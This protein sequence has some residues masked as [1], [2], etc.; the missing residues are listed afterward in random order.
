MRAQL[1]LLSARF[2]RL[3]AAL[4]S[5]GYSSMVL[6]ADGGS[7]TTGIGGLAKGWGDTAGALGTTVGQGVFLLGIVTALGA[8]LKF[9][10]HGED[11][12]QTPL[13]I[14]LIYA[15]AAAAMVGL[16]SLLGVGVGTLFGTSGTLTDATGTN[17]STIKSQ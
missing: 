16:P 6:A 12:R 2:P 15:A 5:A 14:C 10:A 9:K 17:L 13:K 4:A 3:I 11:P 1:Y 7:V 8:A